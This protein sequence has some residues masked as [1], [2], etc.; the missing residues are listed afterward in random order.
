MGAQKMSRKS[1]AEQTDISRR[2]LANKLDGKVPFTYDEFGRV[3]AALSLDWSLL[4]AE[5]SPT[6]QTRGG[7]P[8]SPPDEAESP[9][10]RWNFKQIE[11]KPR[12]DMPPY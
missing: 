10:S 3:V 6:T 5:T 11:L 4:L 7:E 8:E 12:P 1:L 2:A 9:R